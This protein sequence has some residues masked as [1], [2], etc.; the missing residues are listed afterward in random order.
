MSAKFDSEIGGLMKGIAE[1]NSGQQNGQNE[2]ASGSQ[3]NT[4]YQQ[5]QN[6]PGRGGNQYQRGRGQRYSYQNQGEITCFRCGEKGHIQR[7][8]RMRLDQLHRRDFP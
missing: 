8:C 5:N 4:Q 2:Q 1:E 3:S 6:Y 7:G